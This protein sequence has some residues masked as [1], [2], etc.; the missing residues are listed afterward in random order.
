MVVRDESKLSCGVDRDVTRSVGAGL[1]PADRIKTARRILAKGEKVA[2]FF[3][4]GD[5]PDETR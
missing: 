5:P 1:E 4:L 3:R 2:A